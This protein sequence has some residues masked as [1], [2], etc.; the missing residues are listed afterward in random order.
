MAG[1]TKDDK[2]KFDKALVEL[3]EKLYLTMCGRQQKLSKKGEEYG[4]SSTVLCRTEDFFGPE[5]FKKAAEITE[6]EAAETITAQI[7]RLNPEAD[8]R[9][10]SKFIGGR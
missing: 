2:S 3:Q 8:S 6:K 4:W 5:V 10:I 1:I 7:L 9:K